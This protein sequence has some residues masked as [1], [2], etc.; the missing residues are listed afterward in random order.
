MTYRCSDCVYSELSNNIVDL[1]CLKHDKI[2]KCM[3]THCEE[4]ILEPYQFLSYLSYV[5]NY[6]KYVKNGEWDWEGA[7][8]MAVTQ[9]SQRI[10]D[11]NNLV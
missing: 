3:D 1:R 2:V 5:H 7:D 11:G 8:Q 6:E 10:A 4:L 9:Y